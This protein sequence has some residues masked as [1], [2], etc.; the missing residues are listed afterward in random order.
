[1]YMKYNYVEL[2]S[3]FFVNLIFI[4]LR[5]LEIITLSW[6]FILAFPIFEI[7]LI[8]LTYKRR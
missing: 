8:V 3:F 6:T 1:M 4:I 5:Y 2:I 7:I